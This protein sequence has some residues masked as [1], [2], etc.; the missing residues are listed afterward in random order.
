MSRAPLLL[1]ALAFLA[2]VVAD[3]HGL[4]LPAC[5]LALLACAP[6]RTRPVAAFAIAGLL[7]AGWRGHPAR[8]V[9]ETRTLRVTG[10]V[11]GDVSAGNGYTAPLALDG[12]LGSGF[13]DGLAVRA[14][15]REPLAPGERLVVRG[16]LVPF[17]E[18]RNPGEP[19]PREIGLAQGLAGELIGQRVIARAP[20]DPRD[21]RAWAAR[22]RAVLSLRLRAA[23]REPEATVVAGALW[24]ERGMLPRD[25]RDDFRLPARCTCSSPRDCTSA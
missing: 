3:G 16:R 7:C 14:R 25:L 22:L 2:A 6:R 1:P 4:A 20:P 13:G 9:A 17:D 11:V 18:A 19:S 5:A 15:L 12:G 8:I 21:A 23:L 24:G 10:T